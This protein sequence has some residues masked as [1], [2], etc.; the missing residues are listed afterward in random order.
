VLIDTGHFSATLRSAVPLIAALVRPKEPLE[1][2]ER[3]VPAPAPGEVTLRI[4]ACG[5]GLGDW[6]VA[7]LDAL[8][9]TPLVLGQE[10]VGVVERAGEGVTL[11]IGERVGVTPLAWACGACVACER[12]L[13]RYCPA[14]KWHGFSR[15]GALCTH[16]N[17]LAQQLVPLPPGDSAEQAALMGSGWTALGALRAGTVGAGVSTGIF[18]L[19]GVGHLAFALAQQLGARVMAIEPDLERAKLGNAVSPYALTREHHAT[20]DAAIVCVPSAQ[21]VQQAL[22]M[23][24]S[25]G[26]LVLA[27]TSPS[28]RVDLPL[29]PLTARGLDVKGSVLGSRADLRELLTLG[30]VPAVTRRPLR[31]AP[32]SLYALRDGGFIGRLVFIP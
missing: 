10:A 8:P 31:E 2:L 11:Q 28:G 16:G 12:G 15:D 30:V 20:L 25:G 9:A 24:R 23:L 22:P 5:L 4:E 3:E 18:G 7:M 13:E 29:M 26:V 27:A 14:A 1:L 17:F 21:A 6:H 32:D 19:G